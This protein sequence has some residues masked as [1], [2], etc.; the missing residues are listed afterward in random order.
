[1]F[2]FLFCPSLF[3]AHLFLLS[4][5]SHPRNDGRRSGIRTVTLFVNCE[6]KGKGKLEIPL[7]KVIDFNSKLVSQIAISQT[8]PTPGQ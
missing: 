5:Y 3:N 8:R 4:L 2:F 6:A 7:N 1:M